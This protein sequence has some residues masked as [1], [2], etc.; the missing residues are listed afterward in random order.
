MG[1]VV[2]EAAVNEYDLPLLGEHEVRF[3][4]KVGAV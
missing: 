1:M 3:A 4:W 2:P